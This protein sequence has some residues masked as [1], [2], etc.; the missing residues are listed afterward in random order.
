MQLFSE[1]PRKPTSKAHAAIPNGMSEDIDTSGSENEIEEVYTIL[2]S[3]LATTDDSSPNETS[4]SDEPF[5]VK[6][7]NSK[8]KKKI[9]WVK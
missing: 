8:N 4:D 1:M 5:E 6:R 2:T 3:R 9:H 7:S